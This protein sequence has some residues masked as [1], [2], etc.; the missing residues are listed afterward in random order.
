MNISLGLDAMIE[1]L[2]L[3]EENIQLWSINDNASNM[4]VAIRESKYMRAG[5]DGC[6]VVVFQ[7][8]VG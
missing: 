5:P 4:H 1:S 2:G 8:R 3:A 6:R 7:V